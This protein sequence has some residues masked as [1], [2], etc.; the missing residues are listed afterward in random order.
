MSESLGINLSVNFKS[1]KGS[2][3]DIVIIRATG[4]L[5]GEECH[6]LCEV[7]GSVNLVKHG[8]SFSST[9]VLSVC[10][11]GGDEVG[12][13]KKTV[14][15]SVHDAEGFLEL[16]DGGVGERFE[17]VGFL[18]H[19]EGGVGLVRTQEGVLWFSCSPRSGTPH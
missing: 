14:L 8:L 10:C 15:V 5:A 1:L 19:L 7:H 18:R 2:K 12:G 3:N 11:E 9:N 13:G 16:L 4:H 17:D 6:H